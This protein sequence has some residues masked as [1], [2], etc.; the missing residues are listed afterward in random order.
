MLKTRH[1]LFV[2]L[3]WLICIFCAWSY[4]TIIKYVQET[5]AS[6]RIS[7][8]NSKNEV[9]QTIFRLQYYP[10]ERCLTSLHFTSI[11]LHFT[12]ISPHPLLA[13]ILIFV[14]LGITGCRFYSSLYPDR[15]LPNWALG[16]GHAILNMQGLLNGIVFFSVS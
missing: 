11:S 16:T 4:V 9:E 13:A 3:I 5:K 15:H 1:V 12:S 7:S 14:W 2:G 10:G 6:L 8:V